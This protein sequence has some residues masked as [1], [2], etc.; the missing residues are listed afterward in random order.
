MEALVIIDVQNDYFPGG[1][2]ELYCAN[3]ALEQVIRLETYFRSNQL[4]VFYVQHIADENAGFFRPG[5]QGVLL[6]PQLLPRPGEIVTKHAPNSFYE[7]DLKSRLSAVNADTLVVCGMM[8]HMCVD[9]TVRY[10]KD[11]GYKIRLI[12]DGCATKDLAW[13][14]IAVSAPAVQTAYMAALT[15]FASVETCEEFL[16]KG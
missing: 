5:T 8:T 13:K 14:G 4:P 10:E 12:S 16:S 15:S 6:H 2:C 9:T 7:T 11:A 1:A 3:E